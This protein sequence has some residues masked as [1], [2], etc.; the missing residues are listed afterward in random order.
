M[1][2]FAER[3]RIP[4]ARP[5]LGF[6]NRNRLLEPA[7]RGIGPGAAR[8]GG[9]PQHRAGRHGPVS[10]HRLVEPAPVGENVP[11]Q[12][13]RR[14][15]ARIEHRGEPGVE[16]GDPGAAAAQPVGHAEQ[17]FGNA[18]GRRGNKRLEAG[19]GLDMGLP[20]PEAVALQLPPRGFGIAGC[21][22]ERRVR[23]DAA[24]AEAGF[25]QA[26][27]RRPGFLHP[28]GK[29]GGAGRGAISPSRRRSGFSSPRKAPFRPRQA[30]FRT[31]ASPAA[32]RAQASPSSRTA[33][34]KALLPG[35]SRTPGRGPPA[36]PLH[37]VHN[38]AQRRQGGARCP[39]AAAPAGR[40]GG[41]HPPGKRQAGFGVA[42]RNL[43][44]QEAAQDPRIAG[45]GFQ[46]APVKAGG[47]RPT[48]NCCSA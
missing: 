23:Q 47:R 19:R 18:L 44:L 11:G 42:G 17:H 5:G 8:L 39:A 34:G 16:Q 41:L 7:Q 20:A 6:Q 14:A 33:A 1:A 38:Q 30:R 21:R 22:P 31:P 9:R 3:E 2:E 48:S 37:V 40:R 4:G 46:G 35:A 10:R 13:D 32:W 28:A 29:P 12:Q 45:V 15:V 27:E 26:S 25:A 24:R 43:H 36:P